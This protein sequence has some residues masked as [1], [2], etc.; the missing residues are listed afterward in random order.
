MK[1]KLTWP[2]EAGPNPS[3]I[4]KKSGKKDFFNV[5]KKNE[6]KNFVRFEGKK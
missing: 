3:K 2:P 4:S 6:K 1:T 5:K